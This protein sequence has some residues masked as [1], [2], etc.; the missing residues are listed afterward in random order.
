MQRTALHIEAS[1]Q[2]LREVWVAHSAWE[3]TRG[4]L[5]RDAP[6]PGS[7]WLLMHC[8]SIHTM[9]M[10]YAIDVAFIDRHGYTHAVHEAVAPWRLRHCLQAHHALELAAGQA[11]ALGLRPG[12]RL[13]ASGPGLFEDSTSCPPPF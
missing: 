1:G 2:P 10:R 12:T 7:A 9:G 11:R 4:L 6:A 5:G 8:R 13:H 3:R